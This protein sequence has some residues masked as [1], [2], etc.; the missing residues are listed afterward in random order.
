[1]KPM[2]S[3]YDVYDSN[4]IGPVYDIRPDDFRKNIEDGL[5]D[6]NLLLKTK[7]GQYEVPLFFVTKA[8]DI[9]FKGELDPWLEFFFC[10][11]DGETD[12]D[13]FK[14]N[15]C[16]RHFTQ[17]VSDNDKMKT[18][19]FDYF[20]I[21]IDAV[22]CDF[23]QFNANLQPNVT[24]DDENYYFHDAQNGIIE[25]VFDSINRPGSL[26]KYYIYPEKISELMEMTAKIIRDRNRVIYK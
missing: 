24:A 25:Y 21:D 23:W 16:T 15:N 4:S 13:M 12:M 1:M 20:G 3:I 18:L 11:E 26:G 2:N 22:K 5:F 9:I 8:W 14:E 19:W 7:G 6:K 10:V 17:A